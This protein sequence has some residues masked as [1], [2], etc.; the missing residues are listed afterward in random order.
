[1][2]NIEYIDNPIISED[3]ISMIWTSTS[4]GFPGGSYGKESTHNTE[5]PSLIPE[6]GRCP[7]ER[8]GYPLQYSCLG[9]PMDS[10]AWQSKTLIHSHPRITNVAQ[11]LRTI[12]FTNTSIFP[13]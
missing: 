13:L 7:G 12:S 3:F 6:L 4:P 9:N 10:G 8:N 2:S 11:I 5:D 1:M